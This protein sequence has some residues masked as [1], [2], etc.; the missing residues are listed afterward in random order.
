MQQNLLRDISALTAVSIKTINKM[1]MLSEICFCDYLNELDM[2]GEDVVNID[3]GIG[4][5][6]LLVVDDTIQYQ[7]R[8]S[9]SLENKLVRTIE[10]KRVP[11]VDTLETNLENKI[12]ATYKELL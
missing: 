2:S 10:D 1:S 11:L 8:P 3:I 5:I 9:Y 7:F 6:S 4:T 12:Q